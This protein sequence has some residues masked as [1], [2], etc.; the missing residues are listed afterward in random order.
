MGKY[1]NR[2]ADKL[3]KD[4]LESFG[5]VLI[6][7][8]KWCGKTTTAKQQA[9]SILEMQDPD[10]REG[11]MTTAQTKP[12]LLLIGD[13]PRLIDEW[14]MAPVLWDA[15]R[16]SVDRKQ[17]AGHYILTGSN[18]VDESKIMHS[19]I[20]RI[21]RMKMYPMSLWE[22]G[23]SNGQISLSELFD[24]PNLEI[25]GI[26]SS[27]TIEELIF[28]ACQG[29]WPNT[30]SLKSDASRLLIAKDYVDSVCQTDMRTIDGTVRNATLVRMIL[31]TYAR[32]LCTLAKKSNMVRDLQADFESLSMPT[33]DNYV[34]ALK[35]LFVIE[36]I[37]AWNPSIRSAT[38]IRSNKKR[39][40][41]DP[42]IAVAA[43]GLAPQRLM[44][45]LKTFGFIFENMAI[46][47]L[48]VYAQ[49]LNGHFSYYHDRYNLEAD[50][51]LHLDDGRY[52]L[53]EFKLGGRDVEN[54]TQ[55]LL[56]IKHLIREFNEREQQ[57]RLREPDLLM[58]ITGGDMAYTCHDGVKIIPLACLKD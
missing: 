46:R 33:F 6:E 28:S 15:V 57:I 51:V 1:S 34:D 26:T 56:K 9:A 36:D 12:S 42:S 49:K 37:E 35:K 41:T 52:A 18:A 44:T 8:P 43:L 16:V 27:M 39:C 31:K 47:D 45:D 14:Q 22:M 21:T 38:V 4:R 25:D 20:G 13:E 29:G 2:I 48:R 55:H 53:I 50:A 19:G 58:V 40:F 32:N 7:G 10:N 54:G 24:Q 23:K 11:Y 30:L 5:A 17:G 3:L